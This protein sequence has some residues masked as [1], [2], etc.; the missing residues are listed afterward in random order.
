MSHRRI[1]VQNTSDMEMFRGLDYSVSRAVQAGRIVHLEGQTGI[2]LSGEG[3]IGEGDPAAQAENAMQCV[4]VL[5]EEAGSKMEDIVKI[6]TYVTDASFRAQVYPVLAKH[7]GDVY[8][9]S[10]G[11][12]VKAL[13]T[14]IVDFEIDVYAVIPGDEEH[15]RIRKG[16]TKGGYL[17]PDM[18]FR[19]S[20][21]VR[22]GQNVYLT[23]ATGLTL[24]GSDFVGKGDPAAQ[25]DNAMRCVKTLLEEVGARMEDICKVT[26]Y[27]TKHEYRADVYPVLSRHMKD[28]RPVSTGLIIPALAAPEIDFEIDVFAVIPEKSETNRRIRHTNTNLHEAVDPRLPGLDYKLARAIRAGDKVFMQGQVG[29][30]FDG[31]FVGKGDPAAQAGNAMRCVRQL[32]EEAGASMEDICKTI[33]YVKDV[34]YRKIVYPVIAEHMKGVDPVSTGVVVDS[35]GHHDV[36]FEIDVFAVVGGAAHA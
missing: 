18:N 7:L 22:A 10:T 33:V 20:K 24:D 35:F 31:G 5:L 1:R 26:T 14:P 21:A 25:A 8:P 36:D 12:V 17:L 27:V 16:T 9:C 15:V 34:S 13:A 2:P 28:V 3:F 6:T 19:A 4:K 32:L 30:T 11:L 23:G 29:R